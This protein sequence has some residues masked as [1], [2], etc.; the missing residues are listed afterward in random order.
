MK[1][2]V[3]SILFVLLSFLLPNYHYYTQR[4]DSKGTSADSLKST[5]EIHLTNIRQLTS[6]WVDAEAYFSFDETRLI[7]QSTRDSF[8]CDQIFTM[9]TDGSNVKL[10][11]TGKG[12]T[13]CAYFLPGDTQII[14]ASTHLSADTCPPHPDY[15]NGYVW[16][17]YPSYDIFSANADG[18]NLKRLTTTYGYDAEATVSPTGDKIVFTSARDGD[19]ELYTMNLDG[20]DQKRLTFEEGYDG[21]AFFSFDGK[22]IVYRAYHPK[23][24][25]ERKDYEDLFKQDLVRPTIMEIYVMDSDGSNITQVTHNGKAN[26]SPFFFPD[27]TRIIF[28]SNLH[29]PKGRTFH[30]YAINSDGTHLERITYAGTFNFFPM[31]TRDGKRLVFVSNRNAKSPHELNVFI[32]DWK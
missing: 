3:L 1:L 5:L 11:S 23:K 30:L 7:F 4:S 13:T 29:D 8:Q 6:G 22:R 31:F 2:T 21:G 28:S 15:S 26:F 32:A 14:Y 17:I 10:V 16:A 25:A 27:N 19:L 12:R 24:E 20:S 18:S 9:N